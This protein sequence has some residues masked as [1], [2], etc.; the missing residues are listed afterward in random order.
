[1]RFRYTEAMRSKVAAD[2]IR[3][4]RRDAGITQVE[5]AARSGVPQP[6]ISAYERGRRQPSVEAV[7][8]LL[9]A[10][11][12]RLALVHDG[13]EPLVP[14]EAGRRLFEVLGLIDVIPIRRRGALEYPPLAG[15]P[16]SAG[17]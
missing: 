11:G 3:A 14:D 12:R 9:S 7:D 1:V 8:R 5:L 15:G 10:L 13:E 16:V 4:A 17:A 2:L 6:V